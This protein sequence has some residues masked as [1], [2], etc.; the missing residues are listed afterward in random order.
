MPGVATYNIRQFGDP[1][2]RQRAREV[3]E[4]DGRLVQLSHDMIETMYAAPG[5]GLA[6]PQ[7]GIERRMFVYDAG[8]GPATIVNPEIVESDGEWTYREGCLSIPELTWAVV[9]P[10]TIH[11]K[12]RDLDGNEVDI[13]ADDFLARVFQHEL[14]HLDGVLYV[15]RLDPDERKKVMKILR[16]RTLGLETGRIVGGDVPDEDEADVAGHGYREL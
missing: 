4:I 11:L 1:V 12:G 3:G 10:R 15:E 2:L 9:R 7:V 5:V 8:D 6:A 13:E 16:A 14:D